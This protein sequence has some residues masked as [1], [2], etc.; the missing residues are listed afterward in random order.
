MEG[1]TGGGAYTSWG[2]GVQLAWGIVSYKLK[3]ELPNRNW[4]TYCI[5]T[6]QGLYTTDNGYSIA[7]AY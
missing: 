6:Q 5:Q 7:K 1:N 2:Q 3:L 4:H